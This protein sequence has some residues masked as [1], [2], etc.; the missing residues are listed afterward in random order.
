MPGAAGRLRRRAGVSGALQALPGIR[1]DGS[2]TGRWG[3]GGRGRWSA[4]SDGGARESGGHGTG[5]DRSQGGR[6]AEAASLAGGRRGRTGADPRASRGWRVGA[7]STSGRPGQGA[8]GG[9]R[10]RPTRG[11]GCAKACGGGSG[12]GRHGGGGSGPDSGRKQAWDRCSYRPCQSAGLGET[13][14]RS[15]PRSAGHR[16]HELGAGQHQHGRPGQH[17]AALPRGVQPLWAGRAR[18][19]PEGGG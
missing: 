13:G 7:G 14:P 6:A 15:C 11:R 1:A 16:G 5:G 9:G 12:G 18:V 8:G 2:A 10:A 4:G 3:G 17:G 19:R